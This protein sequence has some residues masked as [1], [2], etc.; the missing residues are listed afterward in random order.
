MKTVREKLLHECR[1]LLNQF[2]ACNV[3]LFAEENDNIILESSSVADAL[4]LLTSSDDQISHL[5]TEVLSTVFH[6]FVV[7]NLSNLTGLLNINTG[8]S[9]FFPSVWRLVLPHRRW[10]IKSQKWQLSQHV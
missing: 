8:F 2:Q 7:C 6:Q 3:N 9:H 5:K 1:I 4:A 10:T